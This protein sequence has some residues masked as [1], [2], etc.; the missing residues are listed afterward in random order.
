MTTEAGEDGNMMKLS[1]KVRKH[2]LEE[3][4]GLAEALNYTNRSEFIREVLRDTPANSDTWGPRER[5]RGFR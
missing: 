1:V 3:L 5:L 2:L 4:D